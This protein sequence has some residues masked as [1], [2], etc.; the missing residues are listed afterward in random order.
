MGNRY[1]VIVVGGGML[2]LSTVYHLAR[3]GTRLEPMAQYLKQPP[4][5]LGQVTPRPPVGPVPLEGLLE[6]ER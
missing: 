4:E 1:D 5:S 2:G 6:E 3:R